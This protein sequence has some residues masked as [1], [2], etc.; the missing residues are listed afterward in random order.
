MT[1]VLRACARLLTLDVSNNDLNT[2]P[3]WLG[4]LP[5][6]ARLAVEGNPLRSLKRS[7]IGPGVGAPTLKAYLRTRATPEEA[8]QQASEFSNRREHV[9]RTVMVQR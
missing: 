8:A 2:L 7:L 9:P 1:V 3:A 4:F 6:L 5:S